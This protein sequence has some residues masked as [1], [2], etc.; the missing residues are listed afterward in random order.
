MVIFTKP[1]ITDHSLSC[2]HLLGFVNLQCHSHASTIQRHPEY[3]I[4][5]PEVQGTHIHP[6][7]SEE[8]VSKA[9]NNL[10]LG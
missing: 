6:Q 5:E 3:G 4:M 8:V 9:T 1:G 2:Q 7:V 10:L